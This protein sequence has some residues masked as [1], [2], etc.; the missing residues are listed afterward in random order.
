MKRLYA[1]CPNKTVLGNT[2]ILWSGRKEASNEKVVEE[3]L[4]IFA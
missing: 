1:C 2:A 3:N 4:F